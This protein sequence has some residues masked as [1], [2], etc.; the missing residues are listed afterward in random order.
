[1]SVSP[2]SP[3]TLGALRLE[4]P[5]MLAPMA[6]VT[7]HP[8]RRLAHRFGCPLCWSEMIAGAELLRGRGMDRVPTAVPPS[9][10]SGGDPAGDAAHPAPAVSGSAAA[11]G[12]DE[13]EAG[14]ESGARSS[15]DDA[16]P[17]AVQL[18]G[19]DPALLAEAARRLADQGVAVI[20][21]NMG[22]PARKVVGGATG[23]AALMRDER[24]AGQVI[25]RLVRAVPGLPVTVKMRLGWDD[26]SR[27][28]P[29][30]ARIA[31]EAGARLVTVHGRTRAQ[32]YDGAA[33]W[34][35]IAAVKA[36]VRLPVIANGDIRT[37]ADARAC[38][39]RSGADG[40]MIGRAALGAPWRPGLIARALTQG[41]DEAP[42]PPPA[43]C[44]AVLAEHL[45]LLVAAFGPHHGLLRARKHL[46]WGLGDLAQRAAGDPAWVETLTQARIQALAADT[47]AGVRSVL[48]TLG[49]ALG[50]GGDPAGDD[51]PGTV[52]DAPAG[53]SS[54]FF[55][56]AAG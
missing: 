39:R 24:L 37:L 19:R 8:F 32:M 45:D 14:R 1:M 48:A 30:L 15:F 28:A 13:E 10:G 52:P 9:S 51:P 3:V 44:L 47:P 35:A 20:D 2:L 27:N 34:D 36:M 11:T 55:R 33:D 7:D 50:L 25:A 22:C 43:T 29:T 17:L 53:G 42:D 5:V 54:V 16:G 18:A 6:G 26:S 38:L 40:V 46:A 12:G 21:L 23:G 4:V 41:W 31:E 56:P 49:R